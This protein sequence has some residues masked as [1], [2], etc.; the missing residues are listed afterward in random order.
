[1]CIEEVGCP[2]VLLQPR[3]AGK[4]QALGDYATL[5]DIE[6]RTEHR[7]AETD[8]FDSRQLIIEKAMLGFDHSFR[9][10]SS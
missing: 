5:K 4:I 2:M 7:P 6:W 10:V 3:Y 1:M 8:E 9:T